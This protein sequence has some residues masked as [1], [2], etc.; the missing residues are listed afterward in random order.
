MKCPWCDFEG[1]VEEIGIHWEIDH[2][3]TEDKIEELMYE[4]GFINGWKDSEN[5]MKGSPTEATK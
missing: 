1:T 4:Y 5:K 3:L 2:D